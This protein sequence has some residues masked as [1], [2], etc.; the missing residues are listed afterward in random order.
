MKV[1]FIKIY[2]YI[3]GIGKIVC[4]YFQSL[5]FL[6]SFQDTSW[7]FVCTEPIT[8]RIWVFLNSFYFEAKEQELNYYK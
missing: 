3:G 2:Y 1:I 6:S 7:Q 5:S 8:R 4:L